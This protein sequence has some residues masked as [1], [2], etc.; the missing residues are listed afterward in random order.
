MI[1]HRNARGAWFRNGEPIAEHLVPIKVR[2]LASYMTPEC[3]IKLRP[4]GEQAGKWSVS[5][6]VE[7]ELR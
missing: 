4:K 7:H 5:F 6:E 2:Q 3:T 1:Y